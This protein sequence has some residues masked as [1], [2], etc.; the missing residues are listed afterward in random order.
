MSQI[1]SFDYAITPQE[2]DYNTS[3]SKIQL[4]EVQVS[5]GT[6]PEEILMYPYSENLD[7]SAEVNKLRYQLARAL[8]IINELRKK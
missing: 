8:N 1:L 4:P 6:T 2:F 5:S 7:L 3:G